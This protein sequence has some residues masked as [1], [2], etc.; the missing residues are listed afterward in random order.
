MYVYAV[1]KQCVCVFVCV[2]VCSDADQERVCEESASFDLSSTD[3][4]LCISDVDTILKAKTEEH[5]L[6]AEGTYYQECMSR[7]RRQG[8]SNHAERHLH[9]CAF[10]AFRIRTILDYGEYPL[11]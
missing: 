10:S 6:S 7:Q 1:L 2:C 11:W 4:S 5:T 8:A 3:I 9:L